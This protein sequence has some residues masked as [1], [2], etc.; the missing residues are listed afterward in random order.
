MSIRLFNVEGTDRDPRLD[1][2]EP[3]GY[4]PK[5]DWD[6]ALRKA[7]QFHKEGMW[8]SIYDAN[9]ECVDELPNFETVE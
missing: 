8:A 3:Q 6:A 2:C 4:A 5:L 9:G 1:G 7:R